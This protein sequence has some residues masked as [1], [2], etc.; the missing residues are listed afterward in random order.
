ME[1]QHECEYKIELEG[2]RCEL[3]TYKSELA[4]A[5]ERIGELEKNVLEGNGVKKDSNNSSIPP[6]QDQNRA[7][8]PKRE[9]SGKKSGG[10]PGHKGH[11]HPLS[12]TADK[13]IECPL[14]EQCP[15]CGC[16]DLEPPDTILP[17]VQE[18]DI[19]EVKAHV[20]EYHRR[21]ARCRSC[22]RR[23]K[24]PL[25]EGVHG[26]VSIGSLARSISG[27]MKSMHAVSDKRIV[28]L[29]S[30]CFGIK[31]SEGW[32][33]KTFSEETER[34]M[35]EYEK[36]SEGVK[37]SPVDGSDETGVRINGK[38]GYIW[39]FQVPK[40][41]VYF[42]TSIT[43]AFKVVEETL[44]RTFS[45]THVSD[46]YGGQLKLVSNYKQFCLSH[47]SRECRYLI[48]TTDCAF[49][50]QLKQTLNE[51]MDFR[52]EEGE[53]YDPKS[54]KEAIRYAEKKLEK[55][56]EKPPPDE[57][58]FKKS[59]TL[60]KQ[61]KDKQD[62]LLR[63]LYD[64]LV[65]PTNNDSERPLRLVALIRKV[66]GGFKTLPGAARYDVHLSLIQ[67]AK[68]QGLNIFK[69]LQGKSKL[70]FS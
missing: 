67:S 37:A 60:F 65:P 46:R 64:P 13:V 53:A 42:K 11:S 62:C 26:P 49:G 3:E 34:L 16:T 52:R 19:P 70:A 9:A 59:R 63:F 50:A 23:V 25:P 68:R 40:K 21:M 5:L 44:G 69:V 38:G 35:P 58:P 41:L 66:T 8:Y 45:G 2:V 28:Q 27:Y 1:K 15:H 6:S 20:T 32:V 22:K 31:V 7:C 12:D 24:S 29:F 57:E 33:E 36:I 43:R 55:C 39:I 56:F 48:Q 4:K 10:Q 17:R 51:A 47:I 54:C 18:V 30:D 14:P 61:L